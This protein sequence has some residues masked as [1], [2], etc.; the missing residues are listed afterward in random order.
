MGLGSVSVSKDI[1]GDPFRLQIHKYG[2][3]LLLFQLQ[4]VPVPSK[5]SI[6][7]WMVP[8]SSALRILLMR[9]LTSTPQSYYGTIRCLITILRITKIRS[10]VFKYIRLSLKL[11]LSCKCLVLWS[12]SLT[13]MLPCTV[14]CN[15]QRIQPSSQ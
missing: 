15:A 7:G 14:Y 13:P 5:D 4:W 2:A 6:S 1:I 10:L 8:E 12:Y 11:P 9:T 3:A